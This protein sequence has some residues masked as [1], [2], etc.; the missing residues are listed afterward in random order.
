MKT[1]KR[2]KTPFVFHSQLHLRELT[3]VEAKNLKE[4][5][6]QLYKINGS[7]IYTHTHRFLQRHQS[8]DAPTLPSDFAYWVIEALNENKLGEQLATIDTLAYP[9]IRSLREAIIHTIEKAVK[10]NSSLKTKKASAN[11]EFQFI[12]SVSFIFPTQYKVFT[13]QQFDDALHRVSV[14]SIYFHI[15]EARLRLERQTNDFSQWLHDQLGE[16]QLASQVERIDPYAYSLEGLR[17]MIL[18]LIEKKLAEK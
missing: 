4:L 1:K 17:T 3:G 10:K 13:L 2:A 12:K 16:K 14:N 15:F 9:T 8:H 18:R 11:E 7:C 5:L 6:E